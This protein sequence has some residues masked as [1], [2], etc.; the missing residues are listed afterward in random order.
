M[1]WPPSGGF[2]TTCIQGQRRV[3]QV[4]RTYGVEARLIDANGMVWWRYL[5]DV[6]MPSPEELAAHQLGDRLV[7]L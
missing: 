2:V 5:S 1:N 6:T 4:S 7:V 3:M